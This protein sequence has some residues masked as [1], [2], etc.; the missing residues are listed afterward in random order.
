MPHTRNAKDWKV[1]LFMGARRLY[2]E[3]LLAESLAFSRKAARLGMVPAIRPDGSSDT[4]EGSV[5]AATLWAMRDDYP[6]AG[7]I[8]VYDYTKVPG[9]AIKWARG[10]YTPNY[11]VTFSRGGDNDEAVA[12]VL[13]EGANVAAVFSARPGNKLRAG[14][15]L[16]EAFRIRF[17]DGWRVVPVVSGDATDA[18][19]LDT[20]RGSIIGLSF[21]QKAARAAALV[22]A[23]EFVV[24]MDDTRVI[25]I[26]PQNALQAA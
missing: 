14:D 13:A 2:R 12:R 19:F 7:T 25:P 16:P 9:R 1:A 24:A 21:K 15:P 26:A 18:R 22:A 20:A 6:E 8:E 11:S 4:G 3:L 10:G 23:G 5:L 17:P